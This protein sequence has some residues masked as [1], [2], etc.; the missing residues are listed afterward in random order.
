MLICSVQQSPSA[1]PASAALMVQLS[2][3]HV[4]HPISQQKSSSSDSTP[5]IAPL[6]HVPPTMFDTNEKEQSSME[7]TYRYAGMC[8]DQDAER[9]NTRTEQTRGSTHHADFP[10][11]PASYRND[12]A[13]I[14]PLTSGKCSEHFITVQADWSHYVAPIGRRHLGASRSMIDCKHGPARTRRAPPRLYRDARSV[15]V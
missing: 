2:P 14:T 11:Y 9:A 8:S 13:L 7:E 3:P 4:P 15:A 6:S 10:M 12:V 1:R 5:T